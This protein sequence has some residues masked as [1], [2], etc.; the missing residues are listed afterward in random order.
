MSLPDYVELQ[1][2]LAPGGADQSAAEAHGTLCGLLC[3]GSGDLPEAWIQN[4]LADC[5]EG[6]APSGDVHDALRVLYQETVEAMT[7]DEMGFQLLLPEDGQPLAERAQALA[8]WCHGFLYGLAVRGLKPVDELPD[9][10]R[11]ILADLSE[12]SRAAFTVEETEEQGE[13]AYAELVE[14]VRVAVQLF[15]DSCTTP[16]AE[17]VRPPEAPLH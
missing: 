12:L 17:D 6:D 13:E 5:S 16:Q 2:C 14:Y 4:T 7:G 8:S 3:A 1:A 9:E 11:E 10:L 15:F